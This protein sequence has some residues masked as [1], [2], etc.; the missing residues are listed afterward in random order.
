MA[1]EAL[2]SEH[3]FSIACHGFSYIAFLDSERNRSID[4]S[5][6]S[7]FASLHLVLVIFQQAG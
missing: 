5:R 4:K 6:V 3:K 1:Y 2:R 7:T